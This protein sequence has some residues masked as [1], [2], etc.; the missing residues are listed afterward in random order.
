MAKQKLEY[1]ASE[2]KC[3]NCGGSV[4]IAD[5]P[6]GILYRCEGKGDPAGCKSHGVLDASKRTKAPGRPKKEAAAVESNRAPARAPAEDPP[7]RPAAAERTTD[8]AGSGRK[9]AAGKRAGARSGR[10]RRERQQPA[11]GREPEQ[12]KRGKTWYEQL[13]Y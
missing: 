2:K 6:F 8:D 3:N 12:P 7:A 1:R 11:A 10:K 13:G 9:A 4:V 5:S